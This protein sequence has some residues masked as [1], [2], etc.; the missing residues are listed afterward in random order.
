MKKLTE[1]KLSNGHGDLIHP[2][3]DRDEVQDIYRSWR[4]VFNEYDPPLI[5]VAECW[6]AP[7]RKH[8]YASAQG[9]GQ[10][11]S[12]DILLCNFYAAEYRNCIEHSLR[13]SKES[14]SSTT[15]VLSNHDVV[16]HATRFGLPDTPSTNHR[17]F[18]AAYN[19]F[20]V[21]RFKNPKVDMET[22]LRK[23]RA[24]TLMMLGLPGSTYIYQGEE[25]GLPEVI[26]IPD[27]ERQDPHFH[28]TKGEEVGRDGCRVP[29]PW[30][31]SAKNF[32][33]GAGAP[34]HLPQPSW[35]GQYAV[36]VEEKDAGSTLNMYRQAM[37]WRRELQTLEELEFVDSPK[38]ILHYV[39]PG[40]W[41]VFMNAGPTEVALPK[42]KEVLMSSGRE[43]IKATVPRETTV[44]LRSA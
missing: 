11:F 34:A 4:K 9:L 12:F 20:L 15:W 6:V 26:E 38:D 21:D 5:A 41:E 37:K 2:I 17:A 24:A 13:S 22:G 30:V 16:R 39:R 31:Q 7:D 42:G 8:L 32:G 44:W 1:M 27:A 18:T 40:G 33:Y 25:L 10:A 14:G 3:L 43:D 23:A 19:V 28:R 36:D 29:I 35:M